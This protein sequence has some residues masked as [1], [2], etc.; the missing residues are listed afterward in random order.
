MIRTRERGPAG[1]LL[2][3]GVVQRARPLDLP[4]QGRPQVVRQNRVSVLLPFAVANQHLPQ[5]EVEVFHPQREALT[6]P[7]PGSIEK[8][9]DK[10]VLPFQVPDD[11]KCRPVR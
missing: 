9:A 3:V 10:V 7:H 1:S 6:Q 8:A 5:V 2:G 11:A 4:S